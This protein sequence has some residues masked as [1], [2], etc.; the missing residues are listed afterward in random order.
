M[1]ALSV[2]QPWASLIASGQK[3]IELRRWR[4]SYRG[5]LLIYASASKQGDGPK[6]VAVAVVDLI[7]IRPSHADD[8]RAAC[9]EPAARELA[10]VLEN[11]RLI[12]PFY[13]KGKLSVFS[14]ELPKTEN[15]EA[16]AGSRQGNLF[17]ETP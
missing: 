7:D 6:G 15:L 14:V 4:T 17:L 5:P 9:C 8:A 2:R 11:P 3:T 12:T 16:T 10:W 13:V 1:K